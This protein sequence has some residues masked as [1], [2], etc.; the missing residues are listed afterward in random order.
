VCGY[1]P[2]QRLDLVVNILT[3][4]AVVNGT[5]KVFGGA[6]TRPNMHVADVA[7]LYELLLELPA[8]K[9]GGEVYNVGFE[10]HT[11]ADLAELVRKTVLDELPGREVI[12]IITTPSD[13]DRS[14]RITSEKVTRDLNFVPK[15]TIE[16]AI[17]ELVRAFRDG[18][19]PDPFEDPNYVNLKGMQKIG[20][21]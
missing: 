17:R 3:A 20:L 7:D 11:V 4:H 12:E 6:Q 5:I 21:S 1:S 10:N 2:R 9:I 13:D 18:K 14:Y 15:R 8:E 19:L 16:D